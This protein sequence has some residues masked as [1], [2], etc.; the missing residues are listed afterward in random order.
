MNSNLKIRNSTAEFLM[1]TSDNKEDGIEVKIA[2]ENIWLTQKLIAQL[3]DKSVSTIN[4]HLKNLYADEEI[5]EHKTMK[6]FGNSEF[7]KKPTNYY[8]LEAIISVGYRVNSTKAMQFR[9]WATNILK[10]FSIKGFVLDNKR[11]ENGTYLGEDYYEHLLEQIREIRLSERRFYQKITDIYATSIDY[12]KDDNTTKT[13]FAKVQNKLHFAIHGNT[14]AELIYDRAD[15]KKENMGLAS[16]ENSPNEKILKTDVV[17]A[18]N[19][20]S[21][22]ELQSLGRIVNAYLELAENRAKRN[23]PMTMAD[24]SDRLDLF[25]EFDD[26]EVLKDSGKITAKIA[27]EFALSEFEKYRVIQDKLYMSDFDRLLMAISDDK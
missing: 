19:Y 2:D 17:I 23:I 9:Q 10:E 15:A 16:W 4:E 22:D 24:W 20:L 25:L 13:F 1:F 18:K 26:R 11:L 12:N 21:Q 5:L 14:A 7:A 8:N 3:F 6:K 27:K